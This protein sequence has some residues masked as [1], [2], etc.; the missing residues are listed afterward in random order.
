MNAIAEKIPEL[1]GYFVE[2]GACKN[3][4]LFQCVRCSSEIE[5][6]PELP[7]VRCENQIGRPEFGQVV[8]Q[9]IIGD[10]LI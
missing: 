2:H 9:L 3:P 8:F 1:F 6:V 7:D 4:K 5:N 10:F